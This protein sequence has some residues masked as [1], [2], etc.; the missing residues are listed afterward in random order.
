MRRVLKTKFP[1]QDCKAPTE[2]RRLS[3]A[4]WARCE[5]CTQRRRCF[6]IVRHQDAEYVRQM[7][8]AH[9]AKT[10]ADVL[11][12]VARAST[13][14]MDSARE[15][16]A[17]QPYALSPGEERHLLR[18]AQGRMDRASRVLLKNQKH[19][20]LALADVLKARGLELHDGEGETLEV[21]STMPP[22]L[23]LVS[24]DEGVEP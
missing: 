24:M 22:P 18:C 20:G 2:V 1:C 15:C 17:A 3:D 5:R 19:F 12:A 8:E 7:R 14:L 16:L 6:G 9:R 13:A 10:A 23:R 4:T 11:R 21:G